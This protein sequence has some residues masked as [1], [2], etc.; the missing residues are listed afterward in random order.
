MAYLQ[1]YFNGELKFVGTVRQPVTK[2]GRYADNDIVIDNAG[3][4]GHHAVI[5]QDGEDF[6][7]HDMASTNGVFLNGRKITGEQLQFG[8]EIVIHKHKL[9]FTAVNLASETASASQ[10]PPP[11]N[12]NKT[13]EVDV[14]QLQTL[15]QQQQTR[16][17]YLQQ[18]N[19]SHLGYKWMLTK[20]HFDIGNHEQCDLQVPGWFT[21]RLIARISRQSD[22]YY[23]SPETRWRRVRLNGKAVD[24]R[25]KL[26]HR[27]RLIIRNL[28]LMFYQSGAA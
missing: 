26:H 9:K 22:G 15:L 14:S 24:K 11:I 13:M 8:D 4:S 23:L 28:Q 16:T 5:I 6:F 25:I 10:N 2:I 12:Q 17:P 1:V 3:V 18:T 27:D 21:P 19:G 7:V 20:Q